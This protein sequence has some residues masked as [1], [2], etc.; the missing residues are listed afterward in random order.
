MT[1][2]KPPRKLSREA[3][4]EQLIEATI[5]VLAIKGY[6]RVTMSD[7]ANQAGL[8]H[9]LVNFHFQSKELLLAETLTYLADEYVQNWQRALAVAPPEPAA[10]LDALI[11][12]DFTPELCTPQ[13][14]AAWCAFWGEAQSRPLY[15][16]KCGANNAEYVTKLEALC[17]ALLGPSGNAERV[18]RAIRVASEGLW[19]DLVTQA[20]PYTVDEALETLLAV[21]AAFFPQAFTR[22]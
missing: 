16:E 12:A 11:R 22:V 5:A 14:L 21:A 4:R 13:R 17:A 19:M 2:P 6:A 20:E 8:S 18:A 15:Q 9:G 3:R 7:V 10:Q 1:K